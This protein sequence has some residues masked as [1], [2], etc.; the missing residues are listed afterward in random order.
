[1]VSD[2]VSNHRTVEYILILENDNL[3]L[4]DLIKLVEINNG[5]SAYNILKNGQ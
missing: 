1:M 4:R 3:I 5:R 2:L